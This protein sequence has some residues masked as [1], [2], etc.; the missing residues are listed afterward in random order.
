MSID[1]RLSKL[2]PALNARERAVLA[3]RA[4]NAGETEPVPRGSIP[5]DLRHD[6]NR[7]MGLAFVAG[8]QFGTLVH[9]LQSQIDNL[10]VDLDRFDLLE[11]AA[12]MLE[13]DD[14]ESVAARPVRPWRQ[15][16]RS[17]ESVTVPEFLRSLAAELREEAFNVLS[18]RWQELRAVELVTAEIAVTFDGED[19]LQPEV[20]QWLDATKLTAREHLARLGRKRLPEPS[21]EHLQHTHKL[22]DNGFAAMGLTEE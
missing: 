17:K 1:S 18:F 9:V 8:S 2:L 16:R 5:A 14:P 12:T 4:R 19:P 10:S 13:E 7:Y 11:R 6:F 3:L 21:E 22:V 20:R 15:Q